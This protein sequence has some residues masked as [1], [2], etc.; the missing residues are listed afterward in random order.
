M[1]Q[2]KVDSE[3]LDEIERFNKT[4]VPRCLTCKTNYRIVEEESSEV[5]KTWEPTCEC[6]SN[7][8][9]CLG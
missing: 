3:I 4:K 5:N 6:Y 1:S 2:R 7:V 8:R 9:I